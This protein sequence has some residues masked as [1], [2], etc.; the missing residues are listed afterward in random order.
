MG[1]EI[2]HKYLVISKEYRHLATSAEHII[3]GYLCKNISRT[4]RVRISDNKA[5]LTI[6]GKT[7]AD[8]RQEF[9]YLIPLEDAR[10]LLSL[11]EGEPVQKIRYKVP[12]AGY[13]WE[14]DEFK[15]S[16]EG[17]VLAEIELKSSTHDYELPPFVGEE[18]TGNPSYYNS[19][20]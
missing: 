8:T 2:E 15:G 12:Y 3:Q 6:K 16:R 7:E 19:N 11:C 14:V 18:V 4:V 17:L 5:W 20:L 1:L 9:E 13:L 10:N